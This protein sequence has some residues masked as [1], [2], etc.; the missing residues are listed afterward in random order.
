MINVL[1]S[2]YNGEQ[3][4]VEQLDSI[5]AQSYRDF[6]VYVRD[7]GSTDG[8]LN[9]LEKYKHNL[10]NPEQMQIYQGDNVG[11]CNSFFILLKESKGG[12]YWAF[13]DQDDVWYPDKLLHAIKWLENQDP[14]IPMLYHSGIMFSDENMKELEQY[15]IEKYDFCFQKS[16]TS[17]V[18]Y[19]FAMVINNNLRDEFLKCNPKNIFYHDWFIGMI[20]TAFGKY[21]FSEQID[22]AHR[23]HRNNTSAVSIVNKIPLIKKLFTGDL[24][25]E[26]QALEFKRVFGKRLSLENRRVLELFDMRHGKLRKMIVKV[27]YPKRWNPRLFEECG[28]RF[29][30]LI[31]R[32]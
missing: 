31:G 8:T 32:V 10:K 3:F 19:G 29:L 30:M 4:L 16:I 1:M 17:S 12:D 24:Y 6:V 27:L 28:I 7:D 18:F 13:S 14:H 20:V 11:F 15:N 9:L 5:F 25:Y 2:T 22:A 21:Y 23:I 26:R